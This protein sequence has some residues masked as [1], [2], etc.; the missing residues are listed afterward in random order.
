MNFGPEVSVRGSGRKF[1]ASSDI[2]YGRHLTPDLAFS[3]TTNTRFLLEVSA[4]PIRYI[5]AG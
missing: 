2:P 3:Q 5:A 4:I 1:R